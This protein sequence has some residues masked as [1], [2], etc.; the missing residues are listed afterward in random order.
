ML[1]R[2][3]D[4][5]GALIGIAITCPILAIAGLAIMI[6]DQGPIFFRQTRV[7]KNGKGFRII[8]IRTMKVGAESELNQVLPLSRIQGPAYKIPDDPRITRVGKIL[9][10]WSLDELPQFINILRGEMSLVGPRP[11]QPWVV[12]QYSEEQRKRLAVKPGLTGPM[13]INGRGLLGNDERILLEL[14]YVEHHSISGDLVIL[15]R[16]IPEVISGKGAF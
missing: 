4:V 11:E 3:L 10:R 7:G 14:D 9:R 6:E 5:I 15:Y 12:A 1:K 13:Q 2:A 8:K 16:T